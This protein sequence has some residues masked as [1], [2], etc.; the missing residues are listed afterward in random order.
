MK[1]SEQWLYE[2][3]NPGLPTDELAHMITMAGLEV[4]GVEPVAGQFDGVIVAE[5]LRAEQHPN[6]DKLRVCEVSTGS[7]TVQIVCGAPNARAG[8]KTPLAQIGAVL[9]G[10]FKI[11]KAK[12]R[13]VESRGMLCSGAELGLS[14][15]SDGLLEL[16]ADAPLGVDLRE[17]LGLDDQ[18]IEVDLTPNRAD[19][20]GLRGIAR[21]VGVITGSSVNNL[22]YQNVT[23]SISSV[24]DVTIEAEEACPRY[25]GRVIEG[26]D[27][28]RPSPLWMQERLR[29]AG[30]R[31]IDAVVDVTNYV[32]LELGQ[33]M[34]AFDLDKLSGGIVVRA[35]TAG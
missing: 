4:E 27:I 31:S 14:E 24:F 21:E 33:P 32:L 5:V 20:L 19:C 1:I 22:K 18:V 12:L 16:A 23:E 7:D 6:A 10:D 15:D 30:L 28:S 17:Y 29:R 9:P 2:W 11:E 26:V 8:L 35:A 3:V 25:L 13:D 34:H